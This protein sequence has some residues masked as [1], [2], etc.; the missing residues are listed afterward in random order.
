MK[1]LSLLTN[2]THE[3]ILKLQS[4]GKDSHEERKD[5]ILHDDE[6]DAF[7]HL[8]SQNG[9]RVDFVLDNGAPWLLCSLMLSLKS[10]SY[11]QLGS[12]SVS[13]CYNFSPAFTN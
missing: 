7:A 9:A 12:R 10:F 6:K 5:F 4:V 1:D 13:V 8:S 3:D 2:L 11:M